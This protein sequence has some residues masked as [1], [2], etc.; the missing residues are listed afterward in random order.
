MTGEIV[1]RRQRH[2]Q[3]GH[4]DN[5]DSDAKSE[6]SSDIRKEVDSSPVDQGRRVFAQMSLKGVSEVSEAQ[7]ISIKKLV[8]KWQVSTITP[9]NN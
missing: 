8:L 9:T 7:N 4:R 5:T 1:T 2:V 3:L 6:Q